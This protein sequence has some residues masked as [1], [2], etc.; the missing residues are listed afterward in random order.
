MALTPQQPGEPVQMPPVGCAECRR[1]KAGRAE[2]VR[3]GDRELAEA[4]AIV[5][6]R[7]VRYCH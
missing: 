6:G 7:H 5:H 4:W 2:A 1:L 3:A